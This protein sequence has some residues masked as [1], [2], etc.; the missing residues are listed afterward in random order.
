MIQRRGGQ[1]GGLLGLEIGTAPRNPTLSSSNY[2]EPKIP[3]GGW[4]PPGEGPYFLGAVRNLGDLRRKSEQAESPGP[5]SSE[6]WRA[7]SRISESQRTFVSWALGPN[8]IPSV[9]LQPQLT[10]LARA[11]ARK[12]V[13]TLL[14]M[15]SGL[16]GGLGHAEQTCCQVESWRGWAW[17]WSG[18]VPH[19]FAPSRVLPAVAMNKASLHP[20][21]IP[22]FL[23]SRRSLYGPHPAHGPRV[24]DQAGLGLQSPRAVPGLLPGDLITPQG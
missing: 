7:V 18:P 19:S 17:W 9:C 4:L 14:V 2:R 10:G 6:V 22:S 23:F 12:A 13:K 16:P 1:P 3:L 11:V 5:W 15:S 24:H 20:H 8:R 21:P